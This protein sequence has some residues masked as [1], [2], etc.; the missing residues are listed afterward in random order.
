MVRKTARYGKRTK[1]PRFAT[2]FINITT[3]GT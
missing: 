2:S 1:M 3:T